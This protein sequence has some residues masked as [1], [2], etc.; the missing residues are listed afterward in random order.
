LPLIV[1]KIA[2]SQKGS[3]TIADVL[4]NEYIFLF[5]KS[6]FRTGINNMVNIKNGKAGLSLY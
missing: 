1:L 3:A 4:D 2:Q 6:L 5:T